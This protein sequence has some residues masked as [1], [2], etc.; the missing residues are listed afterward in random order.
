MTINEI[1]TV[2]VVG[3]GQMGRGIAQVL[4]TAGWQVILVDVA[5]E[6]L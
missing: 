6:V 3:A 2:G 4:A 1:K 5:D